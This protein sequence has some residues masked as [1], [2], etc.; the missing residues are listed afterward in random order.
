MKYLRVLLIAVFFA[1]LST[2]AHA[3]DEQYIVYLRTDDSALLAAK[4]GMPAFSVVDADTLARLQS[5]DAVLWYEEDVEI[6]LTAAGYSDPYYIKKW[7][8]TM[9]DAQSAWNMGYMGEGIT[10]GVIDSGVQP[11]HPDLAENLLPTVC[12]LEG[13]DRR[14]LRILQDIFFGR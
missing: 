9:I 7:D 4:D 14:S 10:I 3:A 8:L 11:D 1:M 13:V 5:E 12:Y 2:A 6:R